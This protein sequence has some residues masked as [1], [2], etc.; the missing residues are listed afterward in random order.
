MNQKRPVTAAAKKKAAAPVA[1]SAKTEKAAAVPTPRKRPSGGAA[2]RRPRKRARDDSSNADLISNLPDAVLG[3][4]ISLLPTKDGA[5]TQAIAHGWRPLWRSAPLNIDADDL[6]TVDPRY[7][8]RRQGR[9]PQVKSII[10]RILSVHPGPVRRF[11][12]RLTCIYPTKR[13]YAKDAAQ[14]ESWLCSPRLDNLQE[15]HIFF[16]I[17]ILSDKTWKLYRLPSSMLRLAST[18][19]VATI[20]YCD[21]PDELASSLNFPLLKHLT[22]Q[23]VSI[24]ED[25]FHGVFSACHLLETLFLQET[26]MAYLHISSP[27]LRSIGFR[28]CYVGEG[29][30]VIEDTPRLERLLSLGL[31][32][33]TIRVNRAPKL[34]ILGPLSPRNSN[35]QI[36]NLVFQVSAS[37][38]SLCFHS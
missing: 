17:S 25:I 6:C 7:V 9:R 33:E 27:S 21:F 1:A 13:G 19:I 23:H 5:R 31:D 3:T 32:C 24:S 37:F 29:G 35:I 22:L 16:P 11:S 12:Y 2:G 4:I 18:I 10:S 15:L 14:I 38:S 30:L 20:G 26:V 8:S 34:G 28:D 36:G